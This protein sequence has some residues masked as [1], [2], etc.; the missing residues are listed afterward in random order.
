MAHLNEVSSQQRPD[1]K[2]EDAAKAKGWLNKLQSFKFVWHTALYTDTCMLTELSCLS[3]LFQRDNVNIPDVV[4][5]VKMTQQVLDE[6]TTCDGPKVQDVRGQLEGSTV[7]KGVNLTQVEE[8][9]ASCAK[10]KE[11]LIRPIFQ[12]LKFRFESFTQEEVLKAVSSVDP[13]NWPEDLT[14]HGDEE[15]NKLLDHFQ[16]VLSRNNCDVVEALAEWQRSKRIVRKY[17]R[18]MPWNVFESECTPRDTMTFQTS[19]ILF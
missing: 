4:D 14:G 19:C 6:M 1:I 8:V 11:E 2:K 17:H 18:G 7:Y 13:K 5:G 3:H 12:C 9:E 10:W 16:P 15:V